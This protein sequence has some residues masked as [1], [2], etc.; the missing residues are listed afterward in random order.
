[1]LVP[2][3]SA[4]IGICVNVSSLQRQD[5]WRTELPCFAL[6]PRPGPG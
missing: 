3:V 4:E 2:A 6:T 1:M 5:A